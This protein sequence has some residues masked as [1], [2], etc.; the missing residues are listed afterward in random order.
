MIAVI[1]GLESFFFYFDYNMDVIKMMRHFR[2][3]RWQM[4]DKVWVVDKKYVSADGIEAV[5]TRY[6]F[7]FKILSFE[8]SIIEEERITRLSETWEKELNRY[9]DFLTLKGYSEKTQKNYMQHMRRIMGYCM[10]GDWNLEDETLQAYLLEVMNHKKCSRSYVNQAISA[11]KSFMKCYGVNRCLKTLPR[12]KR[13]ELLPKVL[14]QEEVIRIL[15]APKNMKHRAILFTIYASGLRVSEAATLKIS[16]VEADRMLLRVEQGKGAKDRYTLLSETALELLKIYIK[17]YQPKY[18]LFEGQQPGTHISERSIQQ[19]F[20]QA[21]EKAQV[22]KDVGI[23]VMRH[24]F[25]THL[26]EGG[27][28]IRYIQ[29]LLGHKSPK[30]TQ[31]YTHVTDKRLA[32]IKSPLDLMD[33]SD[34]KKE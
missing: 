18:W 15:R 12:P 27:T 17:N 14:S 11:Y 20:K 9:N 32:K 26:L 19:I 29:E 34:K 4:Q 10:Y 31:I 16:D 23:H 28:D 33:F 30:T 1:E 8:Q 22:N 24:S 7:E 5:L 3:A 13:K 21:L 25:A 2:S 6:G